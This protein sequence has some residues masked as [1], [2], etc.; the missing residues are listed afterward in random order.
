[1][2][3][4]R[5]RPPVKKVGTKRGK[6]KED[7]IE[8]DSDLSDN[9]DNEN[10]PQPDEVLI[11]GHG[12][13]LDEPTQLPQELLKTLVKPAGQLFLFGLVNWDIAGR[14]ESKSTTRLHPNIYSPSRFTD[15][16]VCHLLLWPINNSNKNNSEYL[17]VYILPYCF[18]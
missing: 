13:V 12:D 2:S 14:K 16:K 1:M 9:S 10:A 7:V 4:K 18:I 5:K 11:A 3:S 8:I 15:L 17:I 6:R